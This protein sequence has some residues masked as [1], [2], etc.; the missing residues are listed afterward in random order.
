MRVLIIED[1]A[2]AAR[3]IKT[4]IVDI[5]TSI[6]IKSDGHKGLEA[7]DA[8]VPDLLFLDLGLPSLD[9]WAVLERVRS[10]P[11]TANLPV[12]VVT[13]YGA[14]AVRDRAMAAG[15][16]GFISKPFG[17]N[18][19]LAAVSQALRARGVNGRV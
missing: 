15:A 10:N 19:L 17:Q 2:I 3:L 11:R 12:V 13:G 7:L 14:D 16:D 6:R 18:D 9:G 5:A 4:C 1:S 8:E